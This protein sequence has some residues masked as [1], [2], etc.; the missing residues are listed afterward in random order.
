MATPAI[1]SDSRSRVIAKEPAMAAATAMPRSIRFG[2]VRAVIS[3]STWLMPRI[4]LIKAEVAI[5]AA[6]PSSTVTDDRRI[7]TPRSER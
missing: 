4:K 7:S 3:D 6:V 2:E 1:D 5:T